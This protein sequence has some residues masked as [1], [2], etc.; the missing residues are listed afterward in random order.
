MNVFV[1]VYVITAWSQ[2]LLLLLAKRTR[3]RGAI[4]VRLGRTRQ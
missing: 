2:V 4:V 1:R 3:M